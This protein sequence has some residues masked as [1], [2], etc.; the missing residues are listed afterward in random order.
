MNL[1]GLERFIHSP[2]LRRQ[3]EHL[4]QQ[5]FS[6]FLGSLPKVYAGAIDAQVWKAVPEAQD[7]PSFE[8]RLVPMGEARLSK[9]DA[10]EATPGL[11][12]VNSE[13]K[14]IKEV[15]SE[16]DTPETSPY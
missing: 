12:K 11:L 4:L 1:A 8:A 14:R 10:A 6:E 2:K 9:P 13:G 15:V 7:A 16:E 5:R 3:V